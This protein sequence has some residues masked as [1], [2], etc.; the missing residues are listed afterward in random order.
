MTATVAAK[1]S[2]AAGCS[3][4]SA[5]MP[6]NLITLA[7]FSVSSACKLQGGTR[8]HGDTDVGKP[9]LNVAIGQAGVDLVVQ[10]IDDCGGRVSRSDNATK[11]ACLEAG[12]RF[13]Y[14][15]DLGQRLKARRARHA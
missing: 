15:L 3:N 7:H 5:L 6:A 13:R 14:R 2:G 8:K 11:A 1:S 9:G 12:D 4:Q 10:L